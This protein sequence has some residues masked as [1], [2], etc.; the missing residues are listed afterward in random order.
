MFTMCRQMVRHTARDQKQILEFAMKQFSCWQSGCQRPGQLLFK[1][2][3]R[4]NIIQRGFRPS[5]RVRPK[6][7]SDETVKG[8][9]IEA[10]AMAESSPPATWGSLLRTCG[11]HSYFRWLCVRW[12]G[13]LAVRKHEGNRSTSQIAIKLPSKSWR[14]LAR[15]WY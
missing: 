8:P 15:V 4:D 14:T 3:F 11:L 6:L 5:R 12:C 2:S 1:N 9:M 13:N 7:K 10:E